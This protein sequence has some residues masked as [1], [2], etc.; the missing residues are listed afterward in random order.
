[1]PSLRLSEI[2][3][4]TTEFEEFSEIEKRR[5]LRKERKIGA[6]RGKS[7]IKTD[8]SGAQGFD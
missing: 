7:N 1:M 2:E 8:D 6:I 3:D 5:K 4:L